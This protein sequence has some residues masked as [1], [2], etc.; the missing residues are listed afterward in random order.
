M[1]NTLLYAI[2]DRA[3]HDFVQPMTKSEMEEHAAMVRDEAG[4][5]L[6][7]ASK[8]PGTFR[9]A[10]GELGVD[11]DDILAEA[12]AKRA[13]LDEKRR[14]AAKKRKKAKRSR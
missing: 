11:P 5:W 9:W 13:E 3:I 6:R 14:L 7:S 2:L 8:A 10:C 12:V 1:T 4:Q